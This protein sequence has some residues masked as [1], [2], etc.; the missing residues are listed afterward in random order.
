MEVPCVYG[1]ESEFIHGKIIISKILNPKWAR[2]RVSRV[3]GGM[4]DFYRQSNYLN[5]YQPHVDE[6]CEF[7]AYTGASQTFIHSKKN[8]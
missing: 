4:S 6:G 7:H 1:S 5:N 2:V 3:Y 8:I